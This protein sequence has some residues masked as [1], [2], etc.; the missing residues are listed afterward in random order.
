M[1]QSKPPE[2]DM[3]LEG[4]FVEPPQ[5]P[6]AAKIMFWALIIAVVAGAI[7]LAAFALVIALW[8]LPVAV[9]AAVIAWA[10][11]RFQAW[12]AKRS[13]SGQRNLWSP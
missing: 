1:T 3:T 9:G 5:P 8:L 13:L 2:L 10:V 7:S 4:E 12:R 6:I 11:F